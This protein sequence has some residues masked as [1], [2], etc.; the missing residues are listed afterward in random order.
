VR[1]PDHA[2]VRELL[3]GYARRFAEEFIAVAPP[4]ERAQ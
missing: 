1:S 3:D 2:R 4:L